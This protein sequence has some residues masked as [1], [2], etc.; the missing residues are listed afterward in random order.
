MNKNWLVIISKRF[1]KMFLI[2]G[3]GSVLIAMASNP[4]TNLV[5]WKAW[6]AIL[7]TAF[8]TGGLAAIEKWTQGYQP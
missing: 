2:G 1:L 5:E 6:G 7:V 3:I 4:L 8:V